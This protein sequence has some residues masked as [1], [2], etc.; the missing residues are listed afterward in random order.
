MSGII[1]NRASPSPPAGPRIRGVVTPSNDPST[2]ADDLQAC[3]APGKLVDSDT[4]AVSRFAHRVVGDAQG[5][6][7]RA[8]RLYLAVRDEIRYDPYRIGRQAEEHS[9][10]V[11]LER[12][13]GHWLA[14]LRVPSIRAP[15]VSGGPPDQV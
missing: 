11:A 15:A 5:E 4:P 2:A 10:S 8:R 1:R 3:L 6:A 14:P 13:D 7:E 9:A 12:G